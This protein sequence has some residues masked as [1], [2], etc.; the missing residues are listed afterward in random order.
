MDSVIK[1]L[2]IF[3]KNSRICI[4]PIRFNE[5]AFQMR[6]FPRL[7][8]ARKEWQLLFFSMHKLAQ[9]ACLVSRRYSK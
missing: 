2:Q 9:D 8:S 1:L 6:A 7:R 3:G 4:F 5:K